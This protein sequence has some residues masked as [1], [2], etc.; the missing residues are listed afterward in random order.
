MR[1]AKTAPQKIDQHNHSTVL[2]PAPEIINERPDTMTFKDYQIARR[3]SNQAIRER[4]K[5]F[6]VFLA[7]ELLLDDK[8][9][10]IGFR[11]SRA[12]KP[13]GKTHVGTTRFLQMV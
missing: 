3:A 9:R 6:L 12:G 10:S 1:K 13:F 7:N 4:R 5:G 8:N 11:F 2:P